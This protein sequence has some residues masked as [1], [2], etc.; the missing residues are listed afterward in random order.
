LLVNYRLAERWLLEGEL[1]YWV[2]VGGGDFAGDIVRYG[3]GLSYGRRS[4]DDC[5]LTPVAEVVGWTALSGRDLVAR[6]PTSFAVEDAAGQ[7]IVNFKFGLRLGLGELADVYA[8]YG[9]AL[10]GN[11]WYKDTV[12]VEFRLFF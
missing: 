7:T 10:T 8:G 12:R 9:R 1:R 6:S 3:V 5:W 11:T 2:P 4:P